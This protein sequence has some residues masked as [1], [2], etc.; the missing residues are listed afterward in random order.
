MI[1]VILYIFT[2]IM[3]IWAMEGLDINR[4]FKQSRIYQAR[5]IYLMLA[6]SISYLVTN[7]IYDFFI[8]FQI[9]K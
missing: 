7:F 1:K 3:T 4:F 2:L 6:M 9:I 8:S 5:L